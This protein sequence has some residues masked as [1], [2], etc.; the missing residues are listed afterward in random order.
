MKLRFTGQQPTV[1]HGI[2]ELHPGHVRDFPAELAKALL[3]RGEFEVVVPSNKRARTR[4][5]EENKTT[6]KP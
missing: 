5:L 1:F 2:G 4:K 3:A 6:G